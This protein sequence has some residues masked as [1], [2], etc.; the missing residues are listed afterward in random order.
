M[1]VAKELGAGSRVLPIIAN[2]LV[3]DEVDAIFS[4]TREHFGHIDVLIN[5]APWA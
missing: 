5:L 1:S 4:Q 2:S 3:Q